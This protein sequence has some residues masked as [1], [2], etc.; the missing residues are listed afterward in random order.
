MPLEYGSPRD[1][2]ELRLF[3]TAAMNAL[4]PSFPSEPDWF[5]RFQLRLGDH[6][7]ARLVRV[8]GVFAGGLVDLS[9]GQWFGG[10]VV[11]IGGISAVAIAPEQ[12]GRGA[13]TF[14]MREIV[15]ELH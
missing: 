5:E 15:R 7:D 10:R 13:A 2:A 14:L 9:M 8:D 1:D 4:H 6:G 11:P 3:A 12:R